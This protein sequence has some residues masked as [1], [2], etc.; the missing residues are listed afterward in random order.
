MTRGKPPPPNNPKE[1][2][3]TSQGEMDFFQSLA[4]NLLLQS[5]VSPEEKRR[6][7]KVLERNSSSEEEARSASDK[8]N[9]GSDVNRDSREHHPRYMKL[10][11]YDPKQDGDIQQEYLVATRDEVLEYASQCQQGKEGDKTTTDFKSHLA[12]KLGLTAK[13]LE[14]CIYDCDLSQQNL[15]RTNFS[16]VRFN[17]VNMD[18]TSINNSN[19]S[20]TLL[21]NTVSMQHATLT[22]TTMNRAELNVVDMQGASLSNVGLDN[23]TWGRVNLSNTRIENSGFTNIYDGFGTGVNNGEITVEGAQFHQVKG[24]APQTCKALQKKGVEVTRAIS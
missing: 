4:E 20:N 1:K 24:L 2:Q 22:N 19:L 15:D 7:E 9:S 8:E 21:E 10:P 6:A 17:N 18:N 13:D 11:K 3:T 14:I 23:A 5:D 12:K 16:G